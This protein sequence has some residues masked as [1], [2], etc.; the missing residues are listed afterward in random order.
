LSVALLTA[1]CAHRYHDPYYGNYQGSEAQENVYY[2]QWA[3]ENH[4]E[5]R[6]YRHLS[7]GEQKRYWDW[8]HSH[9]HGHDRDNGRY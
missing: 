7:K 9:D 5:R 2:R 1:G 3:R 8:R 6:D 4:I